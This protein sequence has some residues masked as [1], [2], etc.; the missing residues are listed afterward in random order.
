MLGNN[1]NNDSNNNS[2]NNYNISM[3]L[4]LNFAILHK[5]DRKQIIASFYA[6]PDAT[7]RLIW[8]A[9]G[10]SW[11]CQVTAVKLYIGGHFTEYIL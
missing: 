3:E 4:I 9:R 11:V 7:N 8:Q 2:N 10:Y 6:I 5:V 1:N